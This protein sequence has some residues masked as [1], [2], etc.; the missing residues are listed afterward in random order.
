MLEV[1]TNMV[2]ETGRDRGVR[3]DSDGVAAQI[4]LSVRLW[5]VLT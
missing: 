4:N 1:R 5:I 3:K 2:V